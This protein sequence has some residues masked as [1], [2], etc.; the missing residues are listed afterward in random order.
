MGYADLSL[1]KRRTPEGVYDQSPGHARIIYTFCTFVLSCAI[2]IMR[3]KF[4]TNEFPRV[5]SLDRVRS[6][7]KAL[8]VKYI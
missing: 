4:Y 6:L 2:V 3:M 7:R 8:I 5:Y 1:Y